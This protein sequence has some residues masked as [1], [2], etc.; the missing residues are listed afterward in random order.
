MTVVA[1]RRHEDYLEIACDG[2]VTI[3]Q[4]KTHDFWKI[5]KWFS[6]IA[7]VNDITFAWTWCVKYFMFLQRFAKTHLPKSGRIDDIEDYFLDFYEYCEKKDKDFKPENAY[8][9]IYKQ[10]AYT[11]KSGYMIYEIWEYDAIGSWAIQAHTSLYLGKNATES[12]EIACKLWIYVW[13]DVKTVKINILDK[14]TEC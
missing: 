10:R 12:V 1:F 13:W 4:R 5:I 7:T 9:F 2:E 6:K 14:E 8:I 11:I 3:W